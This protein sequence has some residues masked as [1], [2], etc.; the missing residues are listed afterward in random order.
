MNDTTKMNFSVEGDFI[1]KLAHE[2]ITH[3]YDLSA[4]LQLVINCLQ[5]KELTEDEI[6]GMAMKVLDGQSKITGTYPSDSYQYIETP[7]ENHLLKK[8]FDRI[9]DIREK[10]KSLEAENIKLEQRLA[11]IEANIDTSEGKNL[12][13]S[14]KNEYD[15]KL[16]SRDEIYGQTARIEQTLVSDFIN[17]FKYNDNYGWLDPQG[18]FYPVSWSNHAEWANNW[19]MEH[20]ENYAET[21]SEPASDVLVNKGWILLH[22]PARG[23]PFVTQSPIKNMTKHQADFLYQFFVTRNMIDKAHDIMKQIE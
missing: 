15:E 4:A 6:T 18:N 17:A 21:A 16:F 9:A 13:D 1:T 14:Y 3:D 19:L 22:N 20:D 11:F 12:S 23:M 2:K 5:S 7:N 8:Y 10:Y